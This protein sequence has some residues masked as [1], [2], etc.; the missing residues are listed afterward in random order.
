MPLLGGCDIERV[1][2]IYT[3]EHRQSGSCLCEYERWKGG[4]HHGTLKVMFPKPGFGSG[5]DVQVGR[6]AD[7]GVSRWTPQPLPYPHS[8]LF[9]CTCTWTGANSG[10]SFEPFMRCPVI[11]TAFE[12]HVPWD[13]CSQQFKESFLEVVYPPTPCIVTALA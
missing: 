9:S 4:S 11:L 3:S 10:P 2:G 12:Q 6:Q 1:E 8:W 5:L 7:V 13:C